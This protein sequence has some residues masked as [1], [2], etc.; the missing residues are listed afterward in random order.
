MNSFIISQIRT[1]VPIV[2]GALVAWLITLGIEL[3]AETQ[4]SLVI[5]LTGVIQAVYYFLVRL[6]EKKWPQVG[7]LLGVASKPVYTVNK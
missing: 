7:V 2:V 5:T 4:T 1:F 6:L 3:D